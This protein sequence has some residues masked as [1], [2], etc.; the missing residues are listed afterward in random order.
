MEAY[1]KIAPYGMVIGV[2]VPSAT[3]TRAY[4]LKSVREGM[5]VRAMH[6]GRALGALSLPYASGNQ[7]QGHSIQ[8]HPVHN[9]QS[10][11]LLNI[12]QILAGLPIL[13]VDSQAPTALKWGLRVY[14]SLSSCNL[15]DLL[16]QLQSDEILSLDSSSFAD[17][18]VA[19][20]YCL[21]H[22]GVLSWTDK[23]S[24][25]SSLI[26]DLFTTLSSKL[27]HTPVVVRE[28]VK[29]TAQLACTLDYKELYTREDDQQTWRRNHE[30]YTFC[31]NVARSADWFDV[32][33]LALA[34]ARLQPVNHLPRIRGKITAKDRS[35]SEWV[36]QALDQIPGILENEHWA[37]GT[38]S[39]ISD[40]LQALYF[41]GNYPEKPPGTSMQVILHA[42]FISG[43][44]SR[45]SFLLLCEAKHWFRDPHLQLST[46]EDR[47]GVAVWSQ[48]GKVA[49]EA[50]IQW[51]IKYLELG[52]A[53]ANMEAWQSFIRPDLSTWIDLFSQTSDPKPAHA[54][55][56]IGV[57][58][59]Q[60]AI[61]F[62]LIS[63][64]RRETFP[65]EDFNQVLIQVWTPNVGAYQFQSK[66]ERTL[67]LTFKALSDSWMQLDIALSNLP[68][69][70]RLAR[71]T[72]LEACI[73]AH[74]G[75]DRDDCRQVPISLDFKT[76][77][78][79]G[80]RDRIIQIGA[81]A[82]S[83]AENMAT[84]EEL[85]NAADTLAQI[86][87]KIEMNIPCNA[88]EDHGFDEKIKD[89]ILKEI[90]TL[91]IYL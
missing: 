24:F 6:C 87:R 11:E 64:A 8:L 69:L 42:L 70:M 18:L 38:I 34:I 31:S 20:N 43:D 44:I 68:E 17:Y 25:R 19:I 29:I 46:W 82:R 76:H 80:L 61:R 16:H 53:L 78:S 67:A 50:P 52:H 15:E 47:G 49:R 58:K 65:V 14:P 81:K 59:D 4:R 2:A 88:G 89:S 1:F 84:P 54:R 40:L 91:K 22:E 57:D 39:A 72:V 7:L 85:K 36:Y 33:S 41:I 63:E 79:V 26:T 75:D 27:E 48:L 90:D 62:R 56:H 35:A 74:C 83:T 86:L 21:S 23:S 66:E 77:F 32:V 30:I 55:W 28:I 73:A 10:P 60:L 3:I 9:I 37:E 13:L 5:M 45:I 71:T 12:V 51:G